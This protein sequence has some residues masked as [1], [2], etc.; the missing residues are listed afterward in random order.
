[1][2]RPIARAGV[3]A[4][5]LLLGVASPALASNMPNA[6][7]QQDASQIVVKNMSGANIAEARVQTTDGKVWSLGSGGLASNQAAQIAVPARDCITSVAVELKDGRKLNADGLHACNETQIVV[8]K[9]H[10]DLPQQAI[11]GGQQRGTPR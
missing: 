11:P 4:V 10:I 3:P 6:T 5:A 2:P 9:D 1:M 8:Q 7:T